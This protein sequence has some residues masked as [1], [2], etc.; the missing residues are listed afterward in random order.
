MIAA[1]AALG[2]AV[3]LSWPEA[4]A[5]SV[6]YIRRPVKD[7]AA[8]AVQVLGATA[9]IPRRQPIRIERTPPPVLGKAIVIE[10]P[11][12]GSFTLDVEG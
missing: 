2:L 9:T 4:Q 7:D 12:G 8:R 11:G 6:R 10:T 5:E 1:G 3:V